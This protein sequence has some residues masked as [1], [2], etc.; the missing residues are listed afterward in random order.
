M[1]IDKSLGKTSPKK[2][3]FFQALPE[4]PLYFAISG[5][6]FP[7]LSVPKIMFP[8]PENKKRDKF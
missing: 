2:N 8:V 3:V 1:L 5:L 6:F 4:L 7:I